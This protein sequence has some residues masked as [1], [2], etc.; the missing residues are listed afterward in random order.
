MYFHSLAETNQKPFE[1]IEDFSKTCLFSSK[2]V[3]LSKSIIANKTTAKEYLIIHQGKG[4]SA[5]RVITELHNGSFFGSIY[6]FILF[7]SSLSII[8]L[9]LSSFIFGTNIFKRRNK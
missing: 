7:I 1:Q 9:T 2:R 5:Q 8:F 4:V 3:K 6:T